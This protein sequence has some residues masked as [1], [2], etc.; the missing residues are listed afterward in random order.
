[1]V[2]STQA[3][4][5]EYKELMNNSS[6][7]PKE[8]NRRVKDKLAGKNGETTAADY[9]E[10]AKSTLAD[11]SSSN[12][13]TKPTVDPLPGTT[14]RNQSSSILRMEPSRFAA[15]NLKVHSP[16][17]RREIDR[18]K[19]EREDFGVETVTIKVVSEHTIVNPKE[20]EEAKKLIGSLSSKLRKYGTRI[21]D[22]VI[23]IPLKLETDWDE[24]RTEAKREAARF[25]KQSTHHKVV[26][27]AI[28]LQAM[29]GEEE[30][31]AKKLAYEVQQIMRDMKAS[32]DSM[33]VDKIREAA[34]EAKYKA[35]SLAP[36]MQRGALEA[37][38]REA[39]SAARKIVKET[40]E[41][42]GDIERV[43]RQL[44]TSA[45]E[46]ARLMFLDFDVPDEIAG[47]VD[48][49]SNQLDNLDL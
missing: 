32:L 4:R 27:N 49:Q 3:L 14:F 31:M 19:R 36:G 28:K 6:L 35:L 9:V 8:F 17:H 24:E 16:N 41:V 40:K 30:L 44:E 25:N 39:R 22:G 12:G 2:M 48:V 37:A 38:V 34:T 1:M 13:E 5:D 42:A 47:T 29:V 23:A 26:V 18:Q 15:I 7:S 10:A 21:Q 11:L 46:S 33:D 43:K 20:H 45:V